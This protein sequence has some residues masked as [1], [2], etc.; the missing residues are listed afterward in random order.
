MSR[1]PLEQ[2]MASWRPVGAVS[3]KSGTMTG[4]ACVVVMAYL[5]FRRRARSG[6]HCRRRSHAADWLGQPGDIGHLLGWLAGE[7]GE[8]F[9]DRNAGLSADAAQRRCLTLS[10]VIRAQEPEHREVRVGQLDSDLRGELP[11]EVLAPFVVVGQESL[12]VHV[13]VRASDH[14]HSHHCPLVVAVPA[15]LGW[16]FP[17]KDMCAGSGIGRPGSS[18]CQYIQ[19]NASLPQWLRTFSFSRPNGPSTGTGYLPVSGCVS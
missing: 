1:L 14:G 5:S 3:P 10:G 12:R 19:R 16:C 11:G 13:D 8:Q 15:C 7:Q 4:S 6:R 2:M 18:T 17:A 9:L